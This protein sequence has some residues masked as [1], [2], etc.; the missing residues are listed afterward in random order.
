[1]DKRSSGWTNWESVEETQTAD[2]PGWGDSDG[3][4]Q[5]FLLGPTG[6]GTAGQG[7][8][9]RLPPCRAHESSGRGELPAARG[10]RPARGAR[11][12]CSFSPKTSRLSR[13][14][15][16]VPDAPGRIACPP[17]GLLRLFHCFASYPFVHLPVLS[18]RT[19]SAASDSPPK[20]I[21][22]LSSGCVVHPVSG[23]VF[24]A[25]RACRHRNTGSRYNVSSR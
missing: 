15:V 23:G 21:C 7:L 4:K 12:L 9:S 8:G 11:K 24:W 18:L 19:E 1:M 14:T 20:A 3:P 22:F 13:V 16:M 17:P 10:W 25:G 5:T 6:R 2:M